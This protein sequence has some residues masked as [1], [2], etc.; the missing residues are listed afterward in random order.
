MPIVGSQPLKRIR[1]NLSTGGL[2]NGA[3]SGGNRWLSGSCSG[4]ETK[5]TY[6][7]KFE[8]RGRVSAGLAFESHRGA[9]DF[10]SS[11]PNA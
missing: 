11:Y 4:S 2:W 7:K 10:S 5:K 6:F 9:N 3:G 1:V 8:L